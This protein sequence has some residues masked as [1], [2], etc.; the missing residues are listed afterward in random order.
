[1]HRLAGL[2][3]HSTWWETYQTMTLVS[4]RS[5]LAFDGIQPAVESLQ[6]V[7]D[8]AE[9]PSYAAAFEPGSDRSVPGAQNVCR[10][11]RGQRTRESTE[12]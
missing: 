12:E 3:F 8:V 1:M 7:L 4:S 10:A 9:L 5:S 6:L 2:I 11:C